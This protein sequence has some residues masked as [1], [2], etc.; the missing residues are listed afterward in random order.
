VAE[1]SLVE[2]LSAADAASK[3]AGDVNKMRKS[4]LR[5]LEIEMIERGEPRAFLILYMIP[6]ITFYTTLIL[7][8]G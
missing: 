6:G 4:I 1:P 3:R 5:D 2:L 8:L 7:L